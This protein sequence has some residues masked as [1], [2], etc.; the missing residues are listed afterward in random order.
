M[1]DLAT[2]VN[3]F[4]ELIP[5]LRKI[6]DCL[7]TSGLKLSAHK[8]EFST[9]KVNYLGITITSKG[10]SPGSD[11]ILKF[12]DQIRSPATVKQVKCLIGFV[13]FFRN[14]IPSLGDK[15][16]SLYRLLRKDNPFTITKNH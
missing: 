2:G 9:T 14:L 4:D 10:I 6:F 7:R 12:L 1:D 5:G 15:L 8:C 16:L 13:Q 3:E 11:K